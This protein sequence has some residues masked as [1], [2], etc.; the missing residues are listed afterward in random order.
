MRA[1]CETP[2]IESVVFSVI[3]TTR[4]ETRTKPYPHE[5]PSRFMRTLPKVS[6]QDGMAGS[7]PETSEATSVWKK[8]SVPMHDVTGSAES[9]LCVS[10]APAIYLFIRVNV[11]RRVRERVQFW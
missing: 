5:G 7:A 2:F 4:T 11:M 9:G 10:A 8:W 3:I 1:V 6:G